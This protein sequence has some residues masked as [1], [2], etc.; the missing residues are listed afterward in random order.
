MM[1]TSSHPALGFAIVVFSGMMTA[2]F[3]APMKLSRRWAWE[4]TWLVYATLALL[5]I[6]AALVAWSIPHPIAFYASLPPRLLLLPLLFGCG[7]GVAQVTFGLSIA[8]TGMAMAFAIV[9]G[10]SSLLGGIVPLAVFHP[11]DLMSGVGLTFFASAILL[12][13]GLVL[14]AQAG[15]ERERLSAGE[16]AAKRSFRIGIFLCVFTGCFGSMINMGFVFGGG[17][18]QQATAIGISPEKATLAVWFVV[19]GAGYIP[20]LAFTLYLLRKNV[21]WSRFVLSSGRETLLAFAAAVLWLFGMLGYGVG[22]SIMGKFGTSLG[23]AV[24]MAG[25]LL[26]SSALGQMA[27]EWRAALPPTLRRMRIGLGFIVLSVVALGFSG[28]FRS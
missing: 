8:R 28:L 14:F 17:I 22:A 12:A 13:V 2:S 24:C 3:A 5:F 16:S 6:P 23:F 18:A 4:N 7:W 19:L 20:N 25:L 26:W 27:G 11:E 1:Q 21:T 15:R 10:L 9:I